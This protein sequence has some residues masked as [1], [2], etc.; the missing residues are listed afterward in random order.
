MKFENGDVY[1]GQ[2]WEGQK[3]GFGIYQYHGGEIYEGCWMEDMRQGKG[4]FLFQNGDKFFG[5]F[6]QDN[7]GNIF[8]GFFLGFNGFF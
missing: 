2:W 6:A 7:I 8:L 4:R 1:N 5:N 3:S